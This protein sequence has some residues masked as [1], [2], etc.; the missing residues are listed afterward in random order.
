MTIKQK[1]LTL[2]I[3]LTVVCA[4]SIFVASIIL[5][6]SSLNA[7]AITRIDFASTLIETELDRFGSLSLMSAKEMA[8]HTDLREAIALRDRDAILKY[9]GEL[10]RLTDVDFCTILDTTGTVLVRTHEPDNYGDTLTNQD[11]IKAAL[12]GNTLTVVE[13][14]SAVRLSVRT[15]VPVYDEDNNFVGVISVGFR[16]DTPKVV[17]DMK[18]LSGCEVTIFLGDE[19]ISTTVIDDKGERA[20][21]T[22]A[23]EKISAQVLA[24]QTYTGKANVLGKAALAKYLPLRGMDNQVIG[25]IFAGQYTA[26]DTKQIITH[27]VTGLIV[28]LIVL[29]L[30]IVVAVFISKTIENQLKSIIEKVRNSTVVIN[31]STGEMAEISENLADGS[32]KQASAIEETSATMNETASMV[33]QNA[34]NTRVAAQI[35]DNA[36]NAA[37]EAGKVMGELMGTMSELKESSDKVSR[38]VKTIDDIAFQTN[39]L[40]IN[41]T[42]EAARAGGDAGRSFAVVAQEVRSLAQKSA[43]ASAETAEIIEKNITLTNSSRDGAERVGVIAGSNAKS[44]AE[45]SKL[46]SEITAA[47]EEQ[48]SGVKQVNMAISQMEKQ[49]QQ[50]AA[51]AEETT[52]SSQNLQNEAA[53]LNEVVNE[54][55][56]LI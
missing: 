15:G 51:M 16:F 45:L 18:A 47:S 13:K 41:A 32:S 34:E 17:D 22:T 28:T 7:A 56:K 33:A 50:N 42:V 4:V 25:M 26:E 5:F 44:L 55:S 31:T 14:G 11:N 54:A 19:R 23:D 27:V 39:L 10:Q 24:G 53:S 20:V 3:A 40:A 35:A 21:G 8:G 36:L 49:T 29:V 9:G 30:S 12:G 43:G 2:T 6:D 38:I 1:I 46:I 37:N 52:A 48:A